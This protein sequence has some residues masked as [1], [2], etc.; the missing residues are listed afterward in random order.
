MYFCNI[1]TVLEANKKG[2]ATGSA[3]FITIQLAFTPYSSSSSSSS[4]GYSKLFDW[5]VSTDLPRDS[6]RCAWIAALFFQVALRLLRFDFDVFF[7][8][9]AM[10][11]RFYNM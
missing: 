1:L 9:A 7:L 3:F 4:D 5:L 11:V 8:G 10:S 6:A 2:R